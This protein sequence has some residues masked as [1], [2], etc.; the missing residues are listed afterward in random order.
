MSEPLGIRINNPLNIRYHDANDWEGQVGSDSGFAQFDTPENGVRAADILIQNYGKKYGARS[1][2]DVVSRFAPPNE[3]DTDHYIDFVSKQSGLGAD[4]EIDL[5]D[6]ATRRKILAAMARMET[7]YEITGEAPAVATDVSLEEDAPV[8]PNSVVPAWEPSQ[9][10]DQVPSFSQEVA[11]V[12]DTDAPDWFDA[13]GASFHTDNAAVRAFDWLAE[14]SGFKYDPEFDFESA[15]AQPEVQQRLA[16]MPPEAVEGLEGS[17][18]ADHF[19]FLLDKTEK[20]WADEQLAS[21]AISARLLAAIADP[22]DLAVSAATGGLGAVAKLGTLGRVAAVGGS[23]AAGAVAA[24]GLLAGTSPFRSTA[25]VAFAGISA[26]ALG[27]SLGAISAHADRALDGLAVEAARAVREGASIA[28]GGANL[29]N[30]FDRMTLAPNS[31]KFV[32]ELVD[33]EAPELVVNTRLPT[34]SN[35]LH[36][37]DD[38]DTRS[39]AFKIFE[40]GVPVKGTKLGKVKGYTAEGRANSI[41]RSQ[42]VRMYRKVDHEFKSWAKERGYGTLRRTFGHQAGRE[43]REEVGRA[44]KGEPGVSKQAAAAAVEVRKVLA[45]QLSLM[46]AAGVKGAGSIEPNPNYLPRVHHPANWRAAADEF[47]DEGL[48]RLFREAFQRADPEMPIDIA[49]KLA[50]GYVKSVTRQQFNLD[51]N[52]VHGIP[53]DDFDALRHWFDEDEAQEIIEALEA[54]KARQATSEGKIKNLKQRAVFDENVA[55]PMLTKNGDT[56]LLRISD[57]MENDIGKVV[58]RYLQVT[59]GWIGLAKEA[60]IT[61][62]ADVN[63]V[64]NGIR[65]KGTSR[66][67]A[68]VEARRMEEVIKLVS[69][70]HLEHDPYSMGVQVGRQ[71]RAYN[72]AR[73]GGGFGWAQLAEIG[74]ILGNSTFKHFLRALPDMRKM[75]ERG[76]DGNLADDLAA[77]LD[78]ALGAGTDFI[79]NPVISGFD[80]FGLGF[81]PSSAVGR[82]MQAID[83]TLQSAG[84]I[85]AALSGMAPVNAWLQRIASRSSSYRLAE[86][87]SKYDDASKLPKSLKARYADMGWSVAD[88]NRIFKSIR[89]HASW[90]GK[91][92]ASFNFEAWDSKV[93]DT[94][95]MGM[96][97]QLRRVVQENDIGNSFPFMHRELGKILTQFQSFVINAIN[98]QTIHG[99]YFADV[100]TFTAWSMAMFA[101]GLAYTAQSALNYASE[102]AELRK[103]LSTERIATAAFMR[104]GWASLLPQVTDTM[105]GIAGQDKLFGHARSS[106]LGTGPLEG[107]PTY[108]LIR[109]IGNIVQTPGHLLFDDNYNLSQTDIRRLQR[110]AAFGNVTGVRNAFSL[111][112]QDLPSRSD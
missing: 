85:T 29:F 44:V 5:A 9:T 101:G 84:R 83:G 47:G 10:F 49:R 25:D 100:E 2:R 68:E 61:S 37:S 110:S 6:A 28:E 1:I 32:D 98:K 51:V 62:R 59:S 103:R 95:R 108:S 111:L 41:H 50:K 79:R 104:A 76:A 8:V 36:G 87:A 13:L 12:D 48:E 43:F 70:Q 109:D 31:E 69:G 34:F 81:D 78:F 38:A 3:N 20:Q 102:P 11:P 80:E 26:F 107:N 74:N 63:K 112:S 17:L 16:A 55:L 66:P 65:S 14:K 30:R 73:V 56:K 86:L 27:G 39:I 22:V 106:G 33:G 96:H 75:M 24:E 94:W 57:L 4:D 105:L 35:T 19:V 42:A 58:D 46:Q 67:R 21:S 7:G 18:N 54:F 93:F 91:K 82:G 40:T 45:D 72:F 97:R 89:E 90:D 60:G 92:L 23:A 64:I 15:L 53:T 52:L 99:A 77:E 71:V 88:A